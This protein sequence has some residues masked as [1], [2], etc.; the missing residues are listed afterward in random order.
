MDTYDHSVALPTVLLFIHPNGEAYSLAEYAVCS[1]QVFN[2][3][4]LTLKLPKSILIRQ[5][6]RLI[7]LKST[8]F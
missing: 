8:I 5:E 4:Y 1:F 2:A 3:R 7:C 6:A